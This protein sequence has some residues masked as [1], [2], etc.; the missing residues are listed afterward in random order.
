M[1]RPPSTEPRING[2]TAP[3][4]PAARLPSRSTLARTGPP[5]SSKGCWRRCKSGPTKANVTFAAAAQGS[6]PDFT[7]YRNG[8]TTPNAP[9]AAGF[10][11]TTL[12]FTDGTI[13]T[14]QAGSVQVGAAVSI[15]TAGF[16]EPD[17]YVTYAGY[18]ITTAIHELGH[19][20]GLG[21]TGPYNGTVDSTTQQFSAYDDRQYSLMSYIDPFDTTAA[22]FSQEP[23]TGTDWGVD[24]GYYREPHTPMLDDIIAAQQLDGAPI[25][26][27]LT[28]TQT[29]G[30]DCTITDATAFYFDFNQDPNPVVTLFD[31][32]AGNTLDLSGFATGNTVNLNQGSFSSAD[33]LTN[34]IGIAYGTRIDNYLGGA[35]NDTVTLNF[36]T[37]HIDGGAGGT[38]T[39]VLAGVR[40]QYQIG[41]I[42]NGQTQLSGDGQSATLVNIRNIQFNDGS[43][44]QAPQSYAEIWDGG[45]GDFST[46]ALWQSG[47]SPFSGSDV[48]ISEG[49]VSVTTPESI[50]SLQLA[51]GS[52]LG[53]TGSLTV[54]GDATASVL[55]GTVNVGA[56]G[57]LALDGASEL[58]G[59]LGIAAGGTVDLAANLERQR[60]HRGRRDTGGRRDRCG[61][62]ARVRLGQRQRRD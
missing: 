31:T 4:E 17:D 56:A 35:G 6:T 2:A 34:N 15:D 19:V 52:T 30:F 27:A 21:H 37:D 24:D 48:S 62:D 28:Q 45:S 44:V 53:V 16:G 25:S 46:D 43:Q 13:G 9:V 23:V 51:A 58:D 32:A 59:T 36:D 10:A 7:F 18:G 1:A 8:T 42:G 12:S 22:Y 11:D 38:D 50:A 55:A 14:T 47:L 5:D 26:G 29:F 20:I 54:T 60:R 39:V 61:R 33:G 41:Y 49:A 3:L 40:A 57:T